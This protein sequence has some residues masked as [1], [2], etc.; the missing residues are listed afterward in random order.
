MNLIT[1]IAWMSLL[2]LSHAAF[3]LNPVSDPYFGILFGGSYQLDAKFKFTNPTTQQS[4]NG[5]LGFGLMVN[6][7]GQLGYRFCDS[8]RIEAEALYNKNP[9]NFLH[10]GDVSI[11]SPSTSTG[12]RME[13]SSTEGIG[14][15]N[16]YYDF[17]GDGTSN[18]VPYL[19]LG[20]GYAY[21]S[22]VIRFY[23][24]NILVAGGRHG[25]INTNPAGQVI[26]GLSYFLDDFASFSVDARAYGATAS[27]FTAP[28][29]KTYNLNLQVVS[30]NFLF[31]G[32][33]DLA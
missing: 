18:L 12:L 33:F 9:Y 15:I 26:V 13:G 30:V 11:H 4:E 2:L 22:T 19:G 5:T 16:G 10:L 25:Q 1:R 20:V 3:A 14:F 8:F 29:G 6:I 32:A 23:D 7:G 27:T 17:L 28:S 21:I 31:N 24:N